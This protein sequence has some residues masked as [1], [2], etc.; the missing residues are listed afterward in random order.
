ME[1]LRRGKVSPPVAPPSFQEGNLGHCRAIGAVGTHEARSR[2]L[3]SARGQRNRPVSDM[4][5]RPW[6]L[7]I[8]PNSS[9]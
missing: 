6:G 3:S 8:E 7:E 2:G 5:L 9:P 4:V 1:L